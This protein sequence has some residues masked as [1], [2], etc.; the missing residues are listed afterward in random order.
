MTATDYQLIDQKIEGKLSPNE[1][2]RF[3]ARLKQD[4]EFAEAYRIQRSAIRALRFHHDQQL[5]QEVRQMYT[6]SKQQRRQR[7]VRWWSYAAAA[8]IVGLGGLFAYHYIGRSTT[9]QVYATYYTPYPALRATREAT[10]TEAQPYE[11]GMRLYGE[12][13]YAAAIPS[14]KQLLAIDSLRDRTY[15]LL[16]NS[17]LHTNQ[18]TEARRAFA[19]VAASDDALL[20]QQGQW[21]LALSYLKQDSFDQARPILEK[22]AV[23]GMYQKE[24]S[25]ILAAY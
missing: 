23:E 22:L 1:E 10:P 7:T 6:R 16:G 14:L 24:A 18:P 9:K 15:L 12:E 25:E 20:R 19:A 3:E 5:R 13:R 11:T 8:V 4:P 2:Q 17:Y 21:Y